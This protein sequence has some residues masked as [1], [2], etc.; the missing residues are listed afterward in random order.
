MD[1]GSREPL[2]PSL[3]ASNKTAALVSPKP[4]DPMLQHEALVRAEVAALGSSAAS[5]EG[6]GRSFDANYFA[7]LGI[8]HV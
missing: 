8:K 7:G 5:S 4:L 6:S 2:D 1:S 3:K